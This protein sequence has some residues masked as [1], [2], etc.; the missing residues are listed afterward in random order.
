MPLHPG[1]L[2]LTGRAEY[3]SNVLAHWQTASRAGAEVVVVPNDEHGQLDVAA[4]HDWPA[5]TLYNHFSS[6]DELIAAALELLLAEARDSLYLSPPADG[7]PAPRL[8][9]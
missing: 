6:R 5:R 7:D 8:V 1:D 3:G 9:C 2:I 4:L